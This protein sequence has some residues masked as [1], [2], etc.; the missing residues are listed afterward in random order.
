MVFVNA[1]KD[2][3]EIIINCSCGCDEEIHIKKYIGDDV[4]PDDYFITISES[5]FYS[6]QNGILKTIKNR[7]K[8]IWRAISGKE[9]RLCEVNLS[10]T[11]LE[12]LKRALEEV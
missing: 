2:I 7:L 3:K 11:N 1:D 4:I 6:K 5:K 8:S 9:Y 10:K 12:E